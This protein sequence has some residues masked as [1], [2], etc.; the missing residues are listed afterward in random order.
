MTII[1]WSR[2]PVIIIG[3]ITSHNWTLKMKLGTQNGWWQLFFLLVINFNYYQLSDQTGTSN[4]WFIHGWSP[5]RGWLVDDS[6]VADMA[7]C[8]HRP[9]G[10]MFFSKR[11]SISARLTMVKHGWPWL[12]MVNHMNDCHLPCHAI[13]RIHLFAADEDG[14]AH[15]NAL[16]CLGVAGCAACRWSHPYLFTSQKSRLT[17]MNVD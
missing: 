14:E 1:S 11:V 10:S 8:R 3:W 2:Q 12:T 4:G 7:T 17:N 15:R 5:N 6:A 16:E 9:Q 13:K